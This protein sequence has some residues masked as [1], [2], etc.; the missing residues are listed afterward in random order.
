MGGAD[1]RLCNKDGGFAALA[2]RLCILLTTLLSIFAFGYMLYT[3]ALRSA[4]AVVGYLA[5]LGIPFLLVTL[6]RRLINA[7]RPYEAEGFVGEPPRG[8]KGNSF[9]SRH[10]FSAFAIGTLCCFVSPL[11]GVVL[12]A[13]G[14]LMCICRVALKIH[15]VRDVVAGALI[16]IIS[17]VIGALIL[18]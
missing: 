12:L 13:L 3:L 8:G 11:L 5:T 17:S 4:V 15:F 14:V 6:I 7:P 16:G 1:M 18:I 9:P 2:M 10:A